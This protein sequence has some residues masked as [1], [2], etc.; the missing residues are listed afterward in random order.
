MSDKWVDFEERLY[1][2]ICAGLRNSL[3]PEYCVA[4]HG[5]LVESSKSELFTECAAEL[6]V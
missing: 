1:R 2:A 6:L 4:L 5:V 3:S